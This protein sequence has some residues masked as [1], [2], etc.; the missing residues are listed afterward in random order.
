MGNEAVF[1]DWRELATALHDADCHCRDGITFN[2]H[3]SKYLRLAEA[4][5]PVLRARDA[6]RFDEGVAAALDA[7]PATAVNPYREVSRVPENHHA[8]APVQ[9][10][11][12]VTT[13][14]DSF[15]ED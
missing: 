3:A 5:A 2:P 11:V 1:R 15:M 14:L 6:R 12:Q 13:L 10:Q 4:I 9:A 8:Q 7:M